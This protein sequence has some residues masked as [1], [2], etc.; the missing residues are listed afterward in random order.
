ML[1]LQT[2]LNMKQG[3]K[4]CKTTAVRYLLICFCLLASRKGEG[5]KYLVE[6]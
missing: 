3:K 5:V 2:D 6:E 1:K 4:V